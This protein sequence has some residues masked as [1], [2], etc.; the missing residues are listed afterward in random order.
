MRRPPW[1]I[2]KELK[3][4]KNTPMYKSWNTFPP[5]EE[6]FFQQKVPT[7]TSGHVRLDLSNKWTKLYEQ[8]GKEAIGKY[9]G[10]DLNGPDNQT[11]QNHG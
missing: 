7:E 6:D 10:I 11:P 3:E 9:L 2:D 4:Y 5:L 1:N 8:G